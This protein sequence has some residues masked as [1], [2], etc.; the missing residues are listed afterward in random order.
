MAALICAVDKPTADSFTGSGKTSKLRTLPPKAFTSATP[1]TERRAGRIT[2][3]ST[4]RRSSSDRPSPSTVNMNISPSGVVMGA[5]PPLMP[6]GRSP[7]MPDKRSAT[8]WRAQ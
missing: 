8:C 6:P 1:T 4:L 2:Q 7:A 5:M 3:S